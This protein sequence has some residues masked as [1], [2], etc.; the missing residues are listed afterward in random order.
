ML[1]IAAMALGCLVL[2]LIA[3]TSAVPPGVAVRDAAPVSGSTGAPLPPDEGAAAIGSGLPSG[4][5]DAPVAGAHAAQLD[6]PEDP[7]RLDSSEELSDP[8]ELDAVGEA[9]DTDLVEEVDPAATQHQAL[10]LCQ[11]AAEFLDQGDVDDALAALDRAYELMLDLP[12]T[13]DASFLQARDDIRRLV[14][15]QITRVY[16]SRGVAAASPRTSWDLALPMVTNEHV[17]REI[18]SFTTAERE[19]FLAAYKRSGRYRPMMLERLAEAG[20]P[21]QLSWLPLVESGFKT[22]ALSR[23]S[24]LG[25]WQFIRSTGQRFGLTRDAWV[26]ERL[27]PD[28]ATDAA[29]A[30]LTELHGLFG[31][32][33]KALAAYNCGEAR[34]MRLQGRQPD[35]Y[36]DF[37]DLY[38][39]LPRETRRYVPRFLAT[40]LILESP[41]KYGMTLPE[42][43]PA[44][45][46]WTTV[47]VERSVRLASLAESLGLDAGR[48]ADLN[49][50]LRY[51]ATPDRTYGL[52]VPVAVAG[53]VADRI[54]QVQEWRPPQPQVVVHR[55]RR[56]ETLSVIARRY[57]TSVGAI[58]R[59]NRLRSA[60]R[61]WPGQRLQIPVRS[62]AS[63]PSYN[64]AEGTHTVRRGESLYTIA[65]RYSTT[66]ASLK[67]ANGLSSN[68]IQPGQRLKIRPGSRSD[69]RRYQVRP[70]DTLGAI[71]SASSVSLGALLRVNGMS[72]RSTIYPGQ[73]LV[74]PE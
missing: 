11:S 60:N 69:L 29:I 34:V 6:D 19:T 22:K 64:P 30:Y 40:L 53:A 72:Q 73:W 39:L 56:G 44:I 45:E 68:L 31:D 50:E 52:R 24:A 27:D 37:W 23:A 66:V 20:L 10:E 18:R 7:G 8:N 21:S 33:A 5:D 62:G 15:D 4:R 32:W 70:G 3:C 43:D 71:A 36:L 14:A 41:E 59:S 63:G 61:I 26:D 12:T 67:Q 57:G 16:A 46:G 1:V 28:K 17:A 47:E 48:L 65:R 54:V 55:I 2:G 74:L 42:P 58:M 51:A 13:G 25:L 9:P 35:E 38:E 49:P